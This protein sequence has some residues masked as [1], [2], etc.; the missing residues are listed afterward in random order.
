MIEFLC[1]NGHR[2]HCPDEQAGRAAKCPKCGVRF[3]IPEAME[4]SPLAPPDPDSD[5][6]QAELSQSGILSHAAGSG[7]SL[8]K[9]RQIEF[10]CP[11]GH[12]LHSSAKL[13]GRTGQCPQCGSK[14]RIP[15]YDQY[16]DESPVIQEISLGR[17]SN[18]ADSQ[19]G[20]QSQKL[21]V[22]GGSATG[23]SRTEKAFPSAMESKLL[24]AP[25][26]SIAAVLATLW[27]E[28]AKDAV[29]EI[30]LRNGEVIKPHNFAKKL[31]QQEHGVFLVK[32]TDGTYTTVVVAWDAI[33]HVRMSEQQEAPKEFN[34]R[35]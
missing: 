33:S 2:I 5:I 14:F 19:I 12:L 28:K 7:I 26:H 22:P 17:A 8:H 23:I 32:E 9:Q 35:S 29:L 10:L 20:I 13:Q 1:P 16:S 27:E 15:T 25:V 24:G 4:Q 18:K 34:D 31:S 6:F 30:I 21:S 3:R 11:N